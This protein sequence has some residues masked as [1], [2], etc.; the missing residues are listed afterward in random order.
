MRSLPREEACKRARWCCMRCSM[1]SGSL[2]LGDSIDVVRFPGCPTLLDWCVVRSKD[3]DVQCFSERMSWLVERRFWSEEKGLSP[4]PEAWLSRAGSQ[5]QRHWKRWLRPARCRIAPVGKP[6]SFLFFG[7]SYF[8]LL[9]FSNLSNLS[10]FSFFFFFVRA[11][12]CV[13]CMCVHAYL[14]IPCVSADDNVKHTKSNI[15]YDN[16]I[17]K[18]KQM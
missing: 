9:F 11:C 1:G 17:N 4:G 2:T 14:A 18:M 5:C 15:T 16:K 13:S 3:G 10:T 7:V 12:V 6:P 8:F